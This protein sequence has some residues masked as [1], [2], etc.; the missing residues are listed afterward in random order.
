MHR[1]IRIIFAAIAICLVASLDAEKASADG[2]S[3]EYAVKA[4]FIYNF[5]QFV[6]WPASA[7]ES[8]NSPI[9]IGVLGEN[10]FDSSLEQAIQGK[11][12]KGR[13][14]VIKYF[15]HLADLEPCHILFVSDSETSH[16]S[17]VFDKVDD[18]PVLSI[19]DSPDFPWAGGT[20]RFFSDNNKLRFEIN[21]ESAQK[22]RLKISSK[23]LS[24][25][26]VFNRK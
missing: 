25:A 7:F 22:A 9:V 14:L 8:D 3:R 20:I 6:D 11:S 26:R 23:L 17:E 19:G 24:L 18:R 12:V 2:E 4:A 16:L 13:T 15:P 21:T 10:H 1:P 5:A